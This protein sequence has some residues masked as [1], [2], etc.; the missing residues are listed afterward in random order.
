MSGATAV[1]TT[2]P[3][4]EGRQFDIGIAKTSIIANLME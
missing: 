4:A 3:C 2:G 1:Q